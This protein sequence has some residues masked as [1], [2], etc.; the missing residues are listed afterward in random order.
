MIES[1]VFNLNRLQNNSIDKKYKEDQS[2]MSRASEK[3]INEGGMYQNDHLTTLV[4]EVR[5]SFSLMKSLVKECSDYQ[6]KIYT[7]VDEL[8]ANTYQFLSYRTLG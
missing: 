5:K 2:N 6:N 1:S 4:R 7:L 3:T 8:K